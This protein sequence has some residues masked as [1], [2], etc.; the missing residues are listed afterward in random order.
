MAAMIRPDKHSISLLADR[1]G[2]RR[3]AAEDRPLAITLD[4]LRVPSAE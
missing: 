1:P 3:Y 4:G 2:A